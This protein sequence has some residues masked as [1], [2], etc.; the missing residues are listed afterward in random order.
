MQSIERELYA[1]HL[2]TQNI[3][4]NYHEIEISDYTI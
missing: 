2:D 1:K 4:M 3:D